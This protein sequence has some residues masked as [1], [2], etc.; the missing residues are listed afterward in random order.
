MNLLPKS[1][2]EF[3]EKEYWNRFFKQRGKSNFE[4][5]GE[6]LELA[7]LLHKYVK[8]ADEVLVVGCGNSSLSAN[9][10]DVGIRKMSSIDI[11]PVVIKQMKQMHAGQR[12]E[13]E[14]LQ[15]DATSMSF[16]DGKFSVVLDKGTLD[17]L[18]TDDSEETMEIVRKYWSEVIRT[19]RLGGRFICISLL[20]QHILEAVVRHFSDQN[21]MLRVNRCHEAEQ[22]SAENSKDGTA[23]PVFMIIATKFKPMPKK[24]LE[25][26]L[27]MDVAMIQRVETEEEFIEAIRSAQKAAMVVAG[28][29]RMSIADEK[30][31]SLDLYRPGE[32]SAR[33]TIYVLDQKGHFGAGKYASFIVPQ[34]RESEWLFFTPEGRRRLLKTVRYNRLSIVTMHRG[35]Q[36]SSWDAVKDELS[37]SV[38]NLAPADLKPDEIIPYL[39]LGCDLG[40]RE[41][42]HEGKS[43]SSGSFIVEDVAGE[44]ENLFRK[45]I[46]LSNQFV[47]QSE[48]QVKFVKKG[49]KRVKVIDKSYL[50]CQHHL[51]M[52][53]GVQMSA[54]LGAKT[55][56]VSP[57]VL[58]I[59][60]GGGGLCLFMQQCLKSR[61]TAVEIDA[62]MLQVATKFFG[63]EQSDSLRV[64]I[65]DGLNFLRDIEARQEMYDAI[66]F[67][68]DGKD[69]TVGMSCPPVDF[70]SDATLQLVRKS[71][72]PDGMFVL[73]LVCRDESVR[74]AVVKRLKSVFRSVCRYKLETDLNEI[75]YCWNAE[76]SQGRFAIVVKEVS[77][78]MQRIAAEQKLQFDHEFLQEDAFP[79]DIS[80]L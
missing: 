55:A 39:S 74:E 49:K 78:E 56:K 37:S 54:R 57:H 3:G 80:M 67:D 63:L 51:F 50:G 7:E 52:T 33:F 2:K 16:E 5:Y 10:F 15:M 25:V 45:L 73:N 26:C 72:T 1:H 32:D 8:P 17:A 18:M 61:I 36:Y 42:I 76:I 44:G 22:K 38:Q 62:E 75:L 28:L 43:E 70:V 27:S 9:L 13:L 48:A 4:W 31:V 79:S 34:G 20:Q 12:P 14:F 19:L 64:V 59:G 71:L 40:A 46:F 21:F 6:Y 69:P 23:M 11:S 30:E 66:L 29:H 41:I 60:L 35:Q 58:L 65:D 24:L 53:L 77:K 68:V 47:V